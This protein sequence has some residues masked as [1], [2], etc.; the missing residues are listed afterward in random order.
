MVCTSAVNSSASM[1]PDPSL[2]K[3]LNTLGEGEGEGEGKGEGEGE[4]VFNA[5]ITI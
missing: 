4:G 3:V 5:S 1:V 2:S